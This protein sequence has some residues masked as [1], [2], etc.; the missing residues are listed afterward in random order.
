MVVQLQLE[1][2]RDNVIRE[3]SRE[4]VTEG[5]PSIENSSHR[6]FIQSTIIFRGCS[7]LEIKAVECVI[8]RVVS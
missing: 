2:I 8:T 5:V 1:L 4:C 7:L 6:V 3:N